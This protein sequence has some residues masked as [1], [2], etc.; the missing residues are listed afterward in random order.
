[1]QEDLENI[2]KQ[3]QVLMNQQTDSEDIPKPPQTT[4]LPL[5]P[6]VPF[7]TNNF[8]DDDLPTVLQ[9]IA[10]Q[11]GIPII[12]DEEVQN[13]PSLINCTITEIPLDRAL[14]IVLAGTPY[15]VKKTPY[16][17][18]VCS[19]DI[20]SPMFSAVSTTRRL[21][22]SYVKADMA[23]SLLSTHFQKYVQ[24]EPEGNT[25]LV[26]A[27]SP[28]VDRIVEDLKQIDQ[29]PT[30]VLLDARI[31]II[32]RGDLLN[33]GVEW[34][35]PK[36][37]AGIFSNNAKGGAGVLPD[38][39]GKWPWGVQIGYAPDATFTN[40]LELA[41]NLLAQNQELR[42][43]AKPQVLAQDGK[44]AQMKVMTEEY[45]MLTAQTQTTY[46]QYS[47]M[48]EIESGTSLQI[49]PHIGDNNDITLE[50]SV[51]VSDS[52]ARG[53]ET[54]L[55]V[56]TRR[57]A[58]NTVRIKDGGTVALAGLT[59][60]RTRTDERR[61]P[62][63]SKLPLIGKLFESTNRENSSREIAVFVTA[64]IVPDTIENVSFE[65]P[66]APAAPSAAQPLPP[67]EETNE[68]FRMSL[69][70]SLMRS[71]SLR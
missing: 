41:L 6:G 7:I 22:L 71:R 36:I 29:V 47:E 10:T 11:A 25:I 60:N 23:A 61:V 66:T 34:G 17:Y 44:E 45:Y 33:L 63:L 31:V 54:D 18:L 50:I 21:K 70:E 69:R 24:A 39:G 48:Q 38:F 43:L 1:M 26:T 58:Q 64:R 49:T 35:W 53:S 40:S 13:D 16:Y 3:L 57:T 32:E 2:R 4:H 65:E 68:D 15:V 56:V 37:Q 14:D 51:E 12:G 28:L 46:Y 19:G 9:V 30:H 67:A 52:I 27:P 55:P 42:T 20:E 59:E 5:E 8:V 62:G